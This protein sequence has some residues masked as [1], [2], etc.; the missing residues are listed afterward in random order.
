MYRVVKSAV[1]PW[2]TKYTVHWL[3]P[4]GKDC[5]LGGSNDLD[6][7]VQIGVE[8]AQEL[9]ENPWET[10]E[11]KY[12]F[13]ENMYIAEG[14]HAINS[15]LDDYTDGMMS[16]LDSRM[17]MKK[18]TSAYDFNADNEYAHTTKKYDIQF[19]HP[20]VFSIQFHKNYAYG[21]SAEAF[22]LASS[23]KEAEEIAERL[24]DELGYDP[25]KCSVQYAYKSLEW[26][27]KYRSNPKYAKDI[28]GIEII[29]MN[30]LKAVTSATTVSDMIGEVANAKQELKKYTR[31]QI[32][33]VKDCYAEVLRAIADYYSED[34]EVEGINISTIKT[35]YLVG[36]V[37][38]DLMT[39]DEFNYIYDLLETIG[40][41][42]AWAVS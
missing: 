14:D 5:L 3:S 16:G 30:P 1:S 6:D 29:A 42:D 33:Y 36:A 7:A 28:D 18:V 8:Q 37:E 17:K 38:D 34:K 21:Y 2:K 20:V 26:W 31:E 13:L 22:I 39:E 32:R 12:K 9:M 25:A 19:D 27:N 4:D 11:R 24:C 10:D 23:Y 41:E 15:E 35:D 40:Q